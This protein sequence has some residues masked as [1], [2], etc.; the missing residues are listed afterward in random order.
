MNVN[1]SSIFAGGVSDGRLNHMV[2][3][4]GFSIGSL[5][6]TYLGAPI[7]K[8]KPKKIHFQAVADKVKLKLAN[9]KASLLSI[10]GRMQLVKSVIQGM[11]VHTMTIYSWPISLLRDLERWIKN[12]IWSGD[13]TKKKLVTV[14]WKKVCAPLEEGG[15]GIRSLVSLNAAS[16]MKTCWELIQSDEQ[17]AIVLRSRVLRS[18]SCIHHHIYSSIWSGA[19]SEF[20]N[21][22]INSKWLVGNGENINCWQDNWCGEILA[23]HLNLPQS[24]LDILP[25]QLSNYI[26]DFRW[27]FP[28]ALTVLYPNL[29][30]LAAQ[31]T[32]PTTCRRD[33]LVWKHNNSGEL[34]LKDAYIFKH[35][36]FPILKWAK[37]IWSEDFPPS[38]SLLVW[39]FMLDKLPT[40]D[41]LLI[42]GCYLPSMCSLCHAC[43][44]SSTHLFL[45]CPYAL[46]LWRWFASTFNCTLNFQSKEDIWSICNGSWNPQCKVV[47]TATLINIFNCIWFARNQSRFQDKNINWKSSIAAVISN[48]A[49]AGNLSKSVA[50]PSISNFVILKKFNVNLHPPRAPRIIEIIWQPPSPGWTKC[51]TDGSTNGNSSSCGGIFRDGNSNLLICFGESTGI[52]NSIHAEISGAMR[53][54]ELAKTHHWTNL[55]LEVDSELVVKAFKNHSLVPWHLR[56]RWLNCMQLTRTMNF[57]ATH[58]YREG[59]ICADSLANLSHNLA[60]LTVWFDLPDCIRSSYGNNRLGLSNFRFVTH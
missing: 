23:S 44:E 9:W 41:N 13:I 8:G 3:M 12:F 10:A 40:D 24:Q 30:V 56:N 17:W 49:L 57:M 22:M 59:N 5:P 39:R 32:I 7:F 34:T 35:S 37:L 29:S 54:I 52:G 38:K 15:L 46:Q 53:A 1:K 19:K 47:L 42:R 2:Q 14:S 50:S 27:S 26:Q 58:I 33:K 36:H 31:V 16:N 25:S 11:L 4:L 51:N 28:L 60:N 6:F 18:N 48:S 21:R 45:E 20:Q 55:W 43:N